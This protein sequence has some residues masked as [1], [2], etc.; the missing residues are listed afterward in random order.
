MDDNIRNLKGS[1]NRDAFKHAHKQTHP[2]HYACDLDLILV[3]GGPPGIVAVFDYKMPNDKITWAEQV[4]YDEL[5]QFWPVFIV[6]GS[7]PE[8]GPFTV[9]RYLTGG[10]LLFERQLR[11]WAGLHQW[12]TELRENYRYIYGRQ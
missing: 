1:K 2:K 12:E 7:S 4:V 10:G 8:A 6:R 5:V 11:D 3:A 9:D